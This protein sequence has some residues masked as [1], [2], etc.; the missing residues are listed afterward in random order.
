MTC[1]TPLKGYRSQELNPETGR[2]SIVFTPKAGYHDRP[3]EVPCGQC[4]GCRME[5]SRQWAMRCLHESSLYENNCFI[6]LTYDSDH[7]PKHGTLL[8]SDFQKFMYRLRDRYGA[9]IRYYHCGEYG[10]KFGRP[11]Y[12]AC[13]FNLDFEDKK[14]WRVQN[15]FPLYTSASLS[16]LW[17]LGFSSV[18]AVTFQSAGYVARY[19]M[20]K[21]TGD[22]SKEHYRRI[23]PETGEIVQI[24][25]EYTTMSNGIGEGWYRKF[26]SDVYPHDFVVIRGQKMRPPKYYD[27]LLEVEHPEEFKQIKINRKRNAKKHS[28]NNSSRRLQVREKI[29]KERLSRLPRNL[30]D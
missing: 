10:S 25:P 15:G 14:L 19:L 7:L 24:K 5:R 6:T 17:P 3:V 28:E 26:I 9:G 8:V 20:K 11:H 21:V 4:V 22:P 29:A 27:S 1:Y 13:L 2:R 12:H 18:G 16:R 30:E 23:H